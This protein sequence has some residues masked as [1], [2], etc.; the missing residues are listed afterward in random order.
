MAL[1]NIMKAGLF[2]FTMTL[3]E[4][5]KS[6][7]SVIRIIN[8]LNAEELDATCIGHIVENKSNA[9]EVYKA[10]LTWENEAKPTLTNLS[11]VVPQGMVLAAKSIKETLLLWK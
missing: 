3:R 8:F 9:I 4:S 1:F 7:V 2:L 6:Y 11:F 5:I 10:T